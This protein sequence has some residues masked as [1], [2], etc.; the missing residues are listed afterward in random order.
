MNIRKQ[1]RFYGM[2]PTKALERM[3]AKQVEKWI[4]REQAL[5]ASSMAGMYC[6][7]IEKELSFTSCQVR[8]QID[9]RV[10]ESQDTGKTAQDAL[11]HTI[12]RL[13]SPWTYPPQ[14][15]FPIHTNEI[16]SGLVLTKT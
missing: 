8:I 6:V 9:A 10:W 4:A 15:H 11:F 13:Q 12:R 3:V 5:S 16:L 2:K 14:T 7:T 1:I